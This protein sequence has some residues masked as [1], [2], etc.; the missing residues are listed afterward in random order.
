V[1]RDGREFRPSGRQM[2]AVA[3]IGSGSTSPPDERMRRWMAA[4][5]KR[6]SSGATRLALSARTFRRSG[7]FP[8]SCQ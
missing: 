1:G 5:R 3:Q 4:D 6:R 8:P 2:L 7:G